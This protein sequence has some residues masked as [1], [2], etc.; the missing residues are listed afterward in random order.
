MLDNLSTF[1]PLYWADREADEYV[2][3]MNETMEGIYFRLVVEV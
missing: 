3:D 2:Q 1:I